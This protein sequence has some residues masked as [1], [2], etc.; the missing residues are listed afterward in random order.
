M[1]NL[2]LVDTSAWIEYLRHTDSPACVSVEELLKDG[3]KTYDIGTC[4]AVRME[5]LAGARDGHQ[6]TKPL[7]LLE[8]VTTIPTKSADFDYAAQ[9]YR[10]C[11]REGETIRN[12]VDC[13][14]GAVAI[15]N[16]ASVLHRDVDFEVMARHT[17]LKIHLPI[18]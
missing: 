9:L 1:K 16:D 8:N 12:M 17:E 6:F 3:R 18:L 5:V 7:R 4:D 2:I 13:I 11:R 15:R 10:T 14:V